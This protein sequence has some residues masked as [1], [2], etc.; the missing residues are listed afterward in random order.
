MPVAINGKQMMGNS[1][2]NNYAKQ[3]R[4]NIKKGGSTG[5]LLV[6]QN[7]Y[8]GGGGVPG[9]YNSGFL[10]HYDYNH[11]A[12]PTHVQYIDNESTKTTLL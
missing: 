1:Q 9:E 2:A 6:A 5:G 12:H 3:D 4:N 11:Y 7:S 10:I 8:P